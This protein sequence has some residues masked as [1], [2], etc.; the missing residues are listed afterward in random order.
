[1]A[2][3]LDVE[4]HYGRSGSGKSYNA[5]E[6]V[7]LEVLAGR[8]V[9]VWDPKG[10]YAGRGARDAPEVNRAQIL[11][12]AAFLDAQ[13][14]DP[15]PLAPLLVFHCRRDEFDRWC[16]W[17]LARG[18]MLAVVDEAQLVMQWPSPACL[19]LVTTCRHQGVDLLISAQRPARISGDVHINC[20]VLR[21][22]KITR[23]Q[24]LE[25]IRDI[26][27]DDFAEGLPAL[28]GW[29]FLEWRP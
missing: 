15:E 19:D 29:N 26:T 6:R 27:G 11:S 21:C 3:F 28:E 14:A 16:R 8:E 25:A 7:Q 13:S 4:E 18:N 5:K 24:D 12:V 2:N 17:V 1:M 9:T 10:E 22:W 20:T 23:R